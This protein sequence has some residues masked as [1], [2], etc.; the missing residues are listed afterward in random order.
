MINDHLTDRQ[1]IQLA[2]LEYHNWQVGMRVK[3]T[4]LEIGEVKQV[5]QTTDGFRGTVIINNHS[6]EMTVLLR[7]SSGIR[8]GDPTTWTNE[9]LRV[10]LPI[11]GAILNQLP[12]IPG[13]IQTAARCFNHL[14]QRWP[15][16]HCYVYGHSLG[17]I[18]GQ[19][20]L[21][22]CHFPEQI[23]GAWLYEGPNLYWLLNTQQR[24]TALELRCQIFNYIDPRDVVA[25][26]YLDD[27][28]TVGLLRV[29]DSV[30]T[31][32]ISQHMWG[33]Y[34]FNDQDHLKL[35]DPWSAHRRAQLDYQLIDRVQ[36][37]QRYRSLLNQELDEQ[38]L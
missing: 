37:L 9:W 24:K 1:R 2:Q 11:G 26:G 36:R 3:L 16:Y 29:V 21:A 19:F 7:G 32:P 25:L 20:A 8:K 4:G 34:R 12:T 6:R 27:Q 10:N 33:G 23:A 30:L 38:F 15:G 22:N 14:F 18:N 17:A 28:H 5:F 35:A 31:N 13:E